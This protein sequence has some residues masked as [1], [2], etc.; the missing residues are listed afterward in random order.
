MGI[1]FATFSKSRYSPFSK[2]LLKISLNGFI[3]IG[4]INLMNLADKLSWPTDFFLI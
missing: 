4:L 2:H 3:I 1:T